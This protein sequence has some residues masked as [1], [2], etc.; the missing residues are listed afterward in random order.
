MSKTTSKEDQ[1]EIIQIFAPLGEELALDIIKHRKGLKCP[2]TP[3][4]A[5]GLMKEYCLT[6]DPVSAAEY[7]LNMGWRGFESGWMKRQQPRGYQRR[8]I[9][10]VA[11]EIEAD[12]LDFGAPVSLPSLARN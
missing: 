10:D 3:R 7:H 12:F 6:G 4:G 2:L 1:A 9:A 11:R 5:K 8:T